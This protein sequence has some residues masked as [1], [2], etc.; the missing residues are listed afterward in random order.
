MAINFKNVLAT[1]KQ[2]IADLAGNTLKEFVTQATADGQ[3]I[4]NELKDDLKTWTKQ[5]AKGDI[6]KDDFSDLVLGQADEIKMI[7]LK[8][9]GLAEVAV[10]QF[11]SDVFNL[12]INTVVGLI[13]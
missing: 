1:L 2:G 3:A 5:L 4:L 12:I 11:K 9:A 10:D 6:S 8:Q 7:A 13:P